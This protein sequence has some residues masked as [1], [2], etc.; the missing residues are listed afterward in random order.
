MTLFRY[1][2]NKAFIM[3]IGAL[4]SLAA[5]IFIGN[6]IGN[7]SM[8]SANDAEGNLIF[9]FMLLSLP[10]MIYLV[11]PFSLCLG[12]LSAQA[13]FSRHVE[14]IA[15]QS[16]SVS[17][18]RIYL[19]YLC[20]GFLG[21]LLMAF[22]S[23]YLYPIA[24][25]QADRIEKFQISGDEI[26]GSFN[27][28]GSRFRDGDDIYYVELLDIDG[29]LMNKVSCYRLSSGKLTRIIKADR[30]TWNGAEWIVAGSRQVLLSEEGIKIVH[31]V[32]KLPLKSSPEDLFMARPQPEVLT[33]PEL[34]DYIG[35][36]RKDNLRSKSVETYFHGRISFIIAPFVM[37]LLV[38]PFGMRF[39]RTGGIARGIALGLVFALSYWA[40]HS[41]MIS[42]GMAGYIGP[43][44]AGWAVNIFA[45]AVSG[46]FIYSKKG[47]YG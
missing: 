19:P 44:I 17:T 4:I 35:K 3:W 24:Q 8:F 38:L 10:E 33:I 45:L 12:I 30:A 6:F 9:T 40:I 23:F 29:Q 21:V 22:L 5:M 41:G 27:V 39:P 13:I 47:A 18:A 20:L 34:N 42:L 28:H 43:V 26:K 36:L 32:D 2:F 11:L 14:T 25:R 16:C 46:V 15:M 37:T 31:G 7:I 1:I